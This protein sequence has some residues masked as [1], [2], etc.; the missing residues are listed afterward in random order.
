MSKEYFKASI[1]PFWSIETQL[2]KHH[3]EYILSVRG[4]HWSKLN[5]NIEWDFPK[6]ELTLISGSLV[7]PS[8]IKCTDGKNSF[9]FMYVG[10]GELMAVKN[11]EYIYKHIYKLD[12]YMTYYWK[13]FQLVLAAN[14]NVQFVRKFYNRYLYETDAS[15]YLLTGTIDA[16]Q[17]VQYMKAPQDNVSLVRKYAYGSTAEKL[18]TRQPY[19]PMPSSVTTTAW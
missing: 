15:G 13:K 16:Y 6:E 11:N 14:P 8:Y 5:N 2:P 18:Y 10:L 9:Y 3:V 4:L 17:Q 1:V 7:N 19:A 12:E